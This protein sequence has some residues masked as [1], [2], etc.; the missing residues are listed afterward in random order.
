MLNINI[1]KNMSKHFYCR[2]S[3]LPAPTLLFFHTENHFHQVTFDQIF[4]CIR[5]I[6]SSLTILFSKV[7]FPKF[8]FFMLAY[9]AILW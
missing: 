7:I 3:L 6:L 2:V 4:G 9:T 1:E 8:K 5:S